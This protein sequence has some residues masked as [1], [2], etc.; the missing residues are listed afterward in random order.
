MNFL[1]NVKISGAATSGYD[2]ETINR[3]L[4]TGVDGEERQFLLGL[5]AKL[6][7]VHADR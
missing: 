2:A 4:A 1:F 7:G 3:R 5:L 6:E